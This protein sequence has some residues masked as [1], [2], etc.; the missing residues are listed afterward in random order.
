MRSLDGHYRIRPSITKTCSS[1]AMPFARQPSSAVYLFV[2]LSDLLGDGTKASPPP[3]LTDN[4]IHLTAY[5]YWRATAALE[6]GLG[7]T[8]LPGP[9]PIEPAEKGS[10]K[11]FT[12]TRE[13]LPPPRPP[14]NTPPAV[15][16]PRDLPVFRVRGLPSGTYQLKIDGGPVATGSAVQWAAGLRLARGPELEQVERL[17]QAIIEKNRLYFYRWRPQNETY[18]YGF[19]KHEQ[20]QNAREIPQFD[21]LVAKQEAEIA[22]LSV[23][24]SHTYELVPTA[25]KPR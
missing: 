13:T 25:E 6:R 22:R 24:V 17:R 3:P 5:G 9:S 7:L 18:L 12:L 4:G 16:L 20:G 19:R 1:I 10:I 15:L 14:A 23:P 8:P 21:P 11:E 2:D